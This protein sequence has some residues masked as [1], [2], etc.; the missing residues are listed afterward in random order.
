MGGGV[1]VGAAVVSFR[2]GLLASGSRAVAVVKRPATQPSADPA[3]AITGWASYDE[4][5]T[6]TDTAATDTQGQFKVDAA[7]TGVM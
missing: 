5:G 6:P 3:T 7:V 4:Y 1:V 2:G